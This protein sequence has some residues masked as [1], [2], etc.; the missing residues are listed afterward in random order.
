MIDT[1]SN[2]FERSFAKPGLT[3]RGE[4]MPQ[5]V[6]EWKYLAG[7]YEKVIWR[8][9]KDKAGL[10]KTVNNLRQKNLSLKSQ[11]EKFEP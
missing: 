7:Q 6:G 1:I 4:K 10:L 5:T 9:T 3:A 2:L 8:L 11:L